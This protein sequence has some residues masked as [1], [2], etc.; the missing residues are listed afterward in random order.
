M[1]R[2]RCL[3]WSVFCQRVSGRSSMCRES[4]ILTQFNKK[5]NCFL[6]FPG[7]LAGGD[8]HFPFLLIHSRDRFRCFDRHWVTFP[9]F[10]SAGNAVII[11][12]HPHVC[13]RPGTEPWEARRHS[14][15][16]LPQHT[17]PGTVTH[18]P[19]CTCPTQGGASM[20]RR[21]ST[22]L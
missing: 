10:L 4:L 6:C 9:I 1:L 22:L 5:A 14:T 2:Q 7:G 12:C 18:A 16:R 21:V 15:A 13:C 11:L 20:T 17:P 3:Y 8:W 19:S